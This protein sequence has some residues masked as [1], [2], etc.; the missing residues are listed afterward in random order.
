[1]TF[2][3]KRCDVCGLKYNHL[4]DGE[5]CR[6]CMRKKLTIIGNTTTIHE[7]L[8]K[9]Y[10]VRTYAS[11]NGYSASTIRVPPILKGKL[12]KIVVVGDFDE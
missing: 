7:A 11:G 5:T 9:E 8:N 1:M 10:K 2:I 4:A 6:N 3:K 12:V